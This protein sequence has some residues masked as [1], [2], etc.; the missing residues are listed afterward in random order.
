MQFPF[1]G[2]I[3]SPLI[4][5]SGEEPAHFVLLEGAVGAREVCRIGRGHRRRQRRR[6]VVGRATERRGA[7]QTGGHEHA[8]EDG[9]ESLHQRRR[10][11]PCCSISSAACTAFEFTS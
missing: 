6:R 5:G 3:A 11:L 10:L 9:F 7:R 4:Q 2:I 8:E 1:R